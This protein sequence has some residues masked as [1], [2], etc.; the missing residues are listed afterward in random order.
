MKNK[1]IT[2][3]VSLV[4]VGM[5]AAACG[6]ANQNGAALSASGTI[7]STSVNIA[8]E[9]GGKIAEVAVNEGNEVKK[10]DL[11]FRVEDDLL[12]SQYDQADASRKVAETAVQAAKDQLSSA[13]IQYDLA[14]QGAQS[15]MPDYYKAAWDKSPMDEF[16]RPAWYFTQS[17]E[18][19]AAQNVVAD[20]Q[21]KLDGKLKELDKVLADANNADFVDLEKRLADAQYTLRAADRTLE[22]A[23]DAADNDALEENAQDVYDLALADLEN[24]QKE[25]DQA[26]NTTAAED[27]LDARAAAA[28]AQVQLDTARN[29]LAE[30]QVGSDSLQVQSAAAAVQQAQS[31][32]DQAQANLAA[33][34]ANVK[35]LNIQLEKTK[36]YAPISGVVLLRNLEEGELVNAGSQV[37]KVGNLDEVKITVYIPEDQYGQVNLGQQVVATVDS[38]PE[39]TYTGQVTYISDE[40]EYTPSNVQTVEGRKSTVFA[41]EIT[42]PNP[43]HDLKS[44]MPAD[45]KFIQ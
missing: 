16:D 5:L 41:V 43:D 36:V 24:V 31:A 27:V 14:A 37:M 13:Q 22:I 32:L 33:A 25:Y 1:K 28:V 2:L 35:T 8:P 23:K 6:G 10:G 9:I 19:T 44:G 4:V 15:A 3:I 40:A 20:A 11:L 26:L 17:E 34:E 45:V 7:S 12:Q 30:V 42:L 39:K 29:L 21:T 18:I 38:F